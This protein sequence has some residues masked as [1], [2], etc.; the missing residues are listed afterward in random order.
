MPGQAKDRAVSA[1]AMSI[2]AWLMAMLLSCIGTPAGADQVIAAGGLVSLGGGRID[3]ACTDLIVGGTLNVDQGTYINIRDVHILAG[4]VL[5][6]GSGSITYAGSFSVDPGGQYNQQSAVVQR[7]P[8]CLGVFFGADPV[9]VPTLGNTALIAL[10]A[11]LLWL[12]SLVLGEKGMLRRR[13]KMR[14]A[15][16]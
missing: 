9:Q 4:G 6:G 15:D 1:R 14:E 10:A 5:N 13:V 2:V 8:V 16:Q 12:G 11:L 7:N 3:L